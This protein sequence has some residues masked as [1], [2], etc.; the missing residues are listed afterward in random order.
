LV[1]F[2]QGK[3]VFGDLRGAMGETNDFFESAL[4]K[5]EYEKSSTLLFNYFPLFRYPE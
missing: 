2:K 3:S 5:F 1:D 4:S